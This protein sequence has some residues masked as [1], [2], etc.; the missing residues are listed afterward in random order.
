[1]Y[2]RF[3]VLA[4]RRLESSFATRIRDGV[5]TRGSR[6]LCNVG[7]PIVK[8]AP[9]RS[10]NVTHSDHPYRRSDSIGS[11]QCAE[12]NLR[13]TH[14]TNKH[15]YAHVHTCTRMY[16]CN[17]ATW[18]LWSVYCIYI[19]IYIYIYTIQYKIIVRPFQ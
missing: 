18:R 6:P 7:P 16:S 9:A 13:L 12:L 3:S 8:V 5:C 4:Q 17:P 2:A 19:Y 14:A 11:C 1:M 10:R 15:R